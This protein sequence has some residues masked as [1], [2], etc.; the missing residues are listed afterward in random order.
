M[1]IDTNYHPNFKAG[2]MTYAAELACRQR[3]KS[4]QKVQ[5]LKEKFINKYKDSEFDVELET[6]AVESIRLCAT[7]RKAGKFKRYIE[8]TVFSS[9]FKKPDKFVEKVNNIIENQIKP[10]ADKSW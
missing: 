5:A 1:K 2:R 7:V 8:E 6:T 4:S 9:I 3:M 10:I